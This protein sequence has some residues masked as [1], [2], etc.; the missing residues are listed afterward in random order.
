MNRGV[1]IAAEVADRPNV[2]VVDQV[3]NGVPVRMAVLFLLLGL[4]QRDLVAAPSEVDDRD[5]RSARPARV[6]RRRIERPCL[7]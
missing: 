5:R 6:E 1:E 4:G 3:R 7:S 2:V